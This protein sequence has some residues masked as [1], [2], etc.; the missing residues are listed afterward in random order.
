MVVDPFV[1]GRGV[2]PDDSR[3]GINRTT[4]TNLIEK[5]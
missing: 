2:R 1:V 4:V 5:T 3:L